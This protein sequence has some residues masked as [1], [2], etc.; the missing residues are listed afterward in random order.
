MLFKTSLREGR[1]PQEWRMAEVVP[2]F[3]KGARTQVGNYRPVSLTSVVCKIMERL[4]RKALLKHLIDN[5]FLAETQHGFVQGRSCTTQLLK[6][7]D[8][9]SEI[10]DSRA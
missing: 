10:L 7:V 8:K 4:I 3:K 9:I 6:L 1:L 5:R 2:I